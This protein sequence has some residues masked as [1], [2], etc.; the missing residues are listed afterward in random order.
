MKRWLAVLGVLLTGALL[1][2]QHAWSQG[3]VANNGLQI[4]GTPPNLYLKFNNGTNTGT[5]QPA[6]LTGNRTWTLPNADG[7]ILLSST[8]GTT[9][10]LLGG[11]TLTSVRELGT[12]SNHD[13]PIITNNIE[14]MRITAAGGVVVRNQAAGTPTTLLQ[15]L[16][17][18][19]GTG[20][21]QVVLQAGAN[22]SGVDLLQWQNNGG[23]PLGS[24]R[25]DGSVVLVY[26]PPAREAFF[27]VAKPSGALLIGI[28][29]DVS[30]GWG[31][32]VYDD[33]TGQLRAGMGKD[34]VSG[35][36]RMGVGSLA[37][38]SGVLL[39]WETATTANEPR[40][41]V[42]NG[43]LANP[44]FLV[45]REGDVTVR[46]TTVAL[47]N[48]PSGSAATEV[49]VWNNSF[50]GRVERRDASGLIGATVWALTGNAITS[51][52]NGLSG[53]FLGTTNAQPLVIATTFTATPQPIQFWTG[54]TERMRITATGNVV[55]Q[56]Q[57]TGTP[58]T[59]LQVLGGN[60]GTGA[61]QVIIRAGTNQA[62]VNLLEWQNN[63]GLPLGSIRPDG[64]VV[65]VYA[66]P[67][68]LPF[69]AVANTSG[70][71]LIGI[72][73]NQ[74]GDEWGVAVYDPNPPYGD[75]RAGMGKVASGEWRI[76]VGDLGA[77]N[78]VLLSW[79]TTGTANEPRIVVANG[80]LANPVFLVDREGDVTVRGTT[81]ALPNI[82]SGSAATEVLVWNNSFGGRVERRDASG[83]IGATVWALTGNAITSAWDGTS[84]N[85][86]GTTND[87]ALV[88]ATTSTTSPQPIQFWTGNNE[89]MR[90]TA[91]GN[92][93]IGTN[94]PAQKLHVVGNVQFTGALMP[95][96]VAG[97]TDQLLVSQGSG[98]AP[99]W[100]SLS[101][102]AGQ[103]TITSSPTAL[104][105]E[106]ADISG[107]TPG[108]YGSATQ[109]PVITVDAKG[110]ITSVS[111]ATISGTVPSGTSAGDMLVW[112][113]SAWTA[114]ALS[115]DIGS[116]SGT[117]AVQVS[118]LCGKP[119]NCT[120]IGALGSGDNGKV[121]MW[122]GTTLQWTAQSV[123]A[124]GGWSLSG[125]S[126]GSADFLGT[127]NNQPLIIKTNGV[128]RMRILANA[129]DPNEGFVGIGL[130]NPT[131]RLELPNIA[132]ERGR[133]RANA[134]MLGSS[135][136]WKED[137]R[138]IPNAL[139]KAL[140]LRGVNFRWKPEYGGT[141]DIGFLAEEVA[142]VVPE[143][144]AYDP[145]GQV[146]AMD[147]ARLT[148]LLVEA[149]KQH[150]RTQE[151]VN[152]RL[153]QENAELRQRVERL[154]SLVEQLLRQ[155]GER[156][157]GSQPSTIQDAWL[158]Q[159]IPNPFAGTTTIPYYIPAGV[160]R[161]E[162]VVRD[163]G[164]REL[165]RL[166]LAERGA[167][168][169]VVLE[170]GLLGSGT[171]EYALVLDGRVVAVK[172]MT[173]MR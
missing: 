145:D 65:L 98:V 104:T 163:V 92:V 73:P 77:Q 72:G 119:L 57:A 3:T 62:T 133:A 76:G 7:E 117:G 105:V 118:G 109:V 82:P 127:T 37:D 81:V 130:T 143:V 18:N 31:V 42:A 161:A 160:S 86:L 124:A 91:T 149:L 141:E 71:P 125:N 153:Q 100:K 12:K 136:R 17:G 80:N 151:Q 95:A 59:V 162:L 29:P 52:W 167:H 79:K 69:F 64:S 55:V 51:A 14:R 137:I 21:T 120:A 50:G 106:L 53:N 25:P 115:G 107:L 170:M 58:T 171:Y 131:F 36:W 15:V 45:D 24:I 27:G 94:A 172:Q 88:I 113:G 19:N 78:G 93:G 152:A 126:V 129:G 123:S 34:G 132:D 111:T 97:N 49:L 139:E 165:K 13:L 85:F 146:G 101:G 173:L 9:A 32:G 11:N 6:T 103:I 44:V 60:N 40:I 10:W 5:L 56:N 157:A 33:A 148:A 112:N 90:I 168:G 48:I 68:R 134:W 47:P 74:S 114:V 41:V 38:Q 39:S 67:T 116:V 63:S 140:A 70:V 16:G 147:Y 108:P 150:V 46:G 96:G 54:N 87:K 164:G 138:P 35:E 154:E 8:I 159:N 155:N 135:M 110:R 102:T 122:D 84:G 166:E 75:L 23:L 2:P 169:Q 26:D 89:R 1:L 156:G 30:G 83:L 61:T 4:N 22:Q 28:G 144:V 20:A 128:E 121:L 158:G 43:N 66:P 99:T 142:R